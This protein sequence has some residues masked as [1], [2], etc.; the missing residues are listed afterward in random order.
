MQDFIYKENSLFAE[1]V[2]IKEIAQKIGTPF[3]CYSKNS[4]LNNFFKFQDSFSQSKNKITI[5]YSVKSNSNLAVVKTLAN[6]GSGGDCV[7][8]GEIRRCKAVG[9]PSDKIIFAGVGKTQSEMRY[10]LEQQILQFNV[11]SEAELESLNQVASTMGVKAPIALRVNPDVDAKTHE[12]ITTGRKEDKFGIAWEDAI[13]LYEKANGLESIKVQGVA[14]HIGSQLSSLEPFKQAFTKVKGLVQEL[15]KRNIKISI[16]NLGGGL[17]ISYDGQVMP[18]TESYAQMVMDIL[19]D[20]NCHLAFEPG[21]VISGNAGSLVSKVI[22]RKDGQNKKFL[23]ID[24]AMNDLLRPTLYDAYHNIIEVNKHNESSKIK[25]DV[26]G[27]VCETGDVFVKNHHFSNNIKTNDL[28]SICNAGA[29]GSVMSST[30]NSRPL[31]P[32]IMVDNKKYTII[33]KRQTYDELMNLDI[34]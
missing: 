13:R 10:A 5:C 7:S 27:P 3:Y 19:D 31:I 29:Y 8:E 21:R 12:K 11:E 25:M 34:L 1:N 4:L 30:Y 23:V 16:I 26:V 20:L 14:V 17:G 6:V 22:Y 18:T 32:E 9:I 15:W 33:R 28:V 24:A 2:S